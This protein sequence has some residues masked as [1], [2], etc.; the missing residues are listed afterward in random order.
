MPKCSCVSKSPAVFQQKVPRKPR[1]AT[2]ILVVQAWAKGSP[3]LV[4]PP[5]KDAEGLLRHL[6]W[7]MAHGVGRKRSR[8]KEVKS[9]WEWF[10]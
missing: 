10:S 4:E 6:A 8:L 2:R 5:P 7:G 9:I 3:D 1:S